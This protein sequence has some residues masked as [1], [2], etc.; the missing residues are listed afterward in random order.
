MDGIG[1]RWPASAVK[2]DGECESAPGDLLWVLFRLT[3]GITASPI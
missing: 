3:E 2:G 1:H